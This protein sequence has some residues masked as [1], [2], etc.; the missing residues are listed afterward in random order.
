MFGLGPVKRLSFSV[1]RTS[2]QIGKSLP[3]SAPLG[4]GYQEVQVPL[5]I[6]TEAS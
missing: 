1:L 5:T 6:D 2:K 4:Q 3:L